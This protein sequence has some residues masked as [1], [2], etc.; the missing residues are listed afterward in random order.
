MPQL[1]KV[2]NF[3]EL[4]GN[5]WDCDCLM[6]NT[7]Y[8]W[9]RDNSVDLDLVYSCPAEFKDT[10]WTIYEEYGYFDDDYI[11]DIAEEMEGIATNND[12]FLTNIIYEVYEYNENFEK[13]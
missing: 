9:C 10:P 6:F 4:N 13:K 1:V 3:T 7:I 2:S 5:P 11:S 8:Y 12:K